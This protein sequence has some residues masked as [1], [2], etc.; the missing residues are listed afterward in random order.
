MTPGEVYLQG[1]SYVNGRLR[2]LRLGEWRQCP[3]EKEA[4]RLICTADPLR[5]DDGD[6]H[7][8]HHVNLTKIVVLGTSFI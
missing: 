1:E 5:G 7:T 4:R 8:L 3:K 2:P 6:M